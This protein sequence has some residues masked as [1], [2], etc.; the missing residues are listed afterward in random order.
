MRVGGTV[1]RLLVVWLASWH[2]LAVSLLAGS[3]GMAGIG[4][5]SSPHLREKTILR[6]SATVVLGEALPGAF[7]M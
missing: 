7:V 5:T 2:E 6:K 3:L 1:P 4:H